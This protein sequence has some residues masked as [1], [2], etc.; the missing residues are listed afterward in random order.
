MRKLRAILVFPVVIVFV[1]QRPAVLGGET[2]PPGISKPVDEQATAETRALFFNLHH[3]APD[4]I[5]FGHQN[6]T[7]FG[8]G[9]AGDPDRSDLKTACGKLPAVYGWDAG[10][11]GKQASG[12]GEDLLPIRIR[13]AYA[14]GGVNTLSWHMGNPLT[15]KNF[16]DRTPAAQAILPGGKANL[17]YQRELDR[18]AAFVRDLRDKNGVPIPIIFRPFHEHTGSWFWWGRGNCSEQEY[19]ALW[20]FTVTYLR[21]EKHLHNLLYAYS[22]AKNLTGREEDYLWG[23]PGDENVDVL[24]YDHYCQDVTEALPG[25]RIV[26]RLAHER[27]KI[28]A[29]TE[30]GV[31]KG[32]S[33]AKPGNYYT[34]R[35][36]NPLKN[37][38]LA[39]GIAYVMLWQNQN[40]NH[41]WIPYGDH[42]LLA[43]FKVMASDP[44]F[45]FEDGLEN[46][47][48]DK[49]GGKSVEQQ[50]RDF[51]SSTR[52]LETGEMPARP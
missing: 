25:L 45:V 31:P 28:P 51:N 49:P 7:L 44:F 30:T 42:T 18:F 9:W 26:M 39:K 22:P 34:E 23:Y 12:D 43:D 47:Y 11:A 5:L 2:P 6:D 15:G 41:Y 35:L 33:Q 14:R 13:E 40:E 52:S 21:D 46:L 17:A 27:G 1:L 8:V 3:L 48:T 38:P 32:M 19:V 10:L 36:L 20:R 24:G 37:D 4:K 29:F 16:Y 50:P